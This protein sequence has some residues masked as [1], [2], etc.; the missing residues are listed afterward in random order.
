MKLSKV[1]GY[2]LSTAAKFFLAALVVVHVRIQTL[3]CSM[4]H[5]CVYL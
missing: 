1:S 2:L 4:Q 3:G 5:C